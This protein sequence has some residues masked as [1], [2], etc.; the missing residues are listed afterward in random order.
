MNRPLP[1]APPDQHARDDAGHHAGP[2]AEGV[3]N[4]YGEDDT[5]RLI[6]LQ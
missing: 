6:V 4:G 1:S 2:H 3:V 5:T